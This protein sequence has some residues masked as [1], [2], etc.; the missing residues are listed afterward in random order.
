MDSMMAFVMGEANR[1]KDLMVFDWDKAA[2]II[3]ERGAT[4]AS[5]GLSGDWGYTGGE[6]FSDGKPNT[7][8]YTYLAS[9]WAVP[10]LDIDGDIIDCFIMEGEV[11]E[12]WGKD[13]PEIKWPESALKE[14]A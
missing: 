9:T 14:L 7:E 12:E 5:A 6:I 8:D 1:G 13:F 10:E 2:R 3:K 4:S 11:P